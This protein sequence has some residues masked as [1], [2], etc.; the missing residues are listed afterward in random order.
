[1]LT[2][3]WYDDYWHAFRLEF[4]SICMTVVWTSIFWTIFLPAN[5]LYTSITVLYLLLLSM[6][7]NHLFL[8]DD[9]VIFPLEYWCIVF[10][11]FAQLLLLCHSMYWN[12]PMSGQDGQKV[13]SHLIASNLETRYLLRSLWTEPRHIFEPV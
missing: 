12:F 6:M 10:N 13:C 9:L 3:G 4:Y 11:I 5:L 8:D 2:A 1:L 7:F